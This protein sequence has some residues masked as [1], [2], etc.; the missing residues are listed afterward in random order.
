[1]VTT[2]PRPGSKGLTIKSI[3]IMNPDHIPFDALIV[4]PKNSGKTR[5]LAKSLEHHPPRKVRL[6]CPDLS[7][8]H[9]QSMR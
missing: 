1:M 2:A 3:K 5:H 9:P 4:A 8:I 6:P 7:N